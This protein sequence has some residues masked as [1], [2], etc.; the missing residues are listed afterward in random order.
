MRK[1]FLLVLMLLA[2][3]AAN[4]HAGSSVIGVNGGVFKGMSDFGDETKTGFGGGVFYDYWFTSNMAAGLD[5]GFN[6]LKHQDDGED[7]AVVFPGSGL[8]GTISDK[9]TIMNYGAHGKYGFPMGESPMH[10]YIV[11]GLGMYSIKETFE[12][13]GFSEE[14]TDSKFGGRGGLGLDYMVNE[15]IGIGAEANLHYI[16]TDEKSTQAVTGVV[17]VTYHLPSA[18]K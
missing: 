6:A 7:A 18:S 4:A 10:P 15:Q 9:L 14:A 12:T 17:M 8:T 11:I 2:L 1:M 13:D 5:F 16:N 3:F